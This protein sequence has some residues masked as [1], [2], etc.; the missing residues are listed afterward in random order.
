MIIGYSFVPTAAEPENLDR[1]CKGLSDS[2]AHVVFIDR[3]H[4]T[5][6]AQLLAATSDRPQ[7]DAA[8]AMA[9]RGDILLAFT[10]LHL[11]RSVAELVQI[12]DRLAANGAFL[13]ILRVAGRQQLDT[14]TPSGAVMLA[15]IGVLAA[16]GSQSSVFDQASILQTGV[17]L[18]G[19]DDTMDLPSLRRSR[20][21]PPTASNMTPEINQLRA[22]GLGATEIARRLQICRSS[23]Y[24]ILQTGGMPEEQTPVAP[25]LPKALP[26]ALWP[27][28][29][30]HGARMTIIAE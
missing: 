29:A 4:D 1:L 2:G 9:S 10:P 15:T 30:A 25:A 24:R 20:G 12:A 7:L 5:E 18:P 13:R 17:L 23:V 14:S 3:P 22:S 8:V 16:Y 6:D 28:P 27:Q 21:R 26:T 19:L 11:A